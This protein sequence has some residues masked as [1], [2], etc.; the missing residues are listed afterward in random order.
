MQSRLWTALTCRAAPQNRR[1]HAAHGDA[2]PRPGG[3]LGLEP[4]ARAKSG[5]AR[6]RSPQGAF[7]GRHGHRG[8]GRGKTSGAACPQRAGAQREAR[9]AAMAGGRDSTPR[10]AQRWMQTQTQRATGA[11]TRSKRK[12]LRARSGPMCTLSQNGYGICSERKKSDAQ[13]LPSARGGSSCLFDMR[14]EKFWPSGLKR[15]LSNRPS[16]R[17][18][19]QSLLLSS[20]SR[21]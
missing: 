1:G 3:A 14:V 7:R 8:N 18:R 19:V 15:W 4:R 16:G 6:A 11:R 5:C 20:R 9:V 17:A 10:H 21:A 2:G 12:G 13:L